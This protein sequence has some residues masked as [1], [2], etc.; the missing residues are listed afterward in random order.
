MVGVADVGVVT[1]SI[2][3]AATSKKHEV[4]NVEN[5]KN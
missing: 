5:D 2:W 1:Y 3:A 4:K